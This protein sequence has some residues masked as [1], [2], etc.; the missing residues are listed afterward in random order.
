M[1]HN[2]RIVLNLSAA[3][4]LTAVFLGTFAKP[5][6]S[7][8]TGFLSLINSYR[9]QSGAGALAEDQNL[10]NSACWLAADMGNKGYFDHTDSLGRTMVQRLNAFGV[11][12]SL[13]ENIFYTTA[14]SS[15]NYAFDAWKNS[16]GH[17]ANML[18]SA[19]TRIGIG[20][21]NIHSRWFW[22][23]DFANGSAASL[24][25]QCEAT[26]NSPPPPSV[27]P[28]STPAPPLP[29]QT[30]DVQKPQPTQVATNATVQAQTV[31]NETTKSATLSSK[32]VRFGTASANN[33]GVS[34]LVKNLEIALIGLGN[35]VLF[36]VLFWRFYNK[37]H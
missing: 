34:V 11:S 31:L 27:K 1:Q 16:H 35:L 19:Y 9:Q 32:T 36:G 8:T 14:G 33:F 22:A 29:T 23:T 13:A 20:R 26:T 30:V 12:G 37:F 28:K 18:N 3:C 5:A 2:F 25:N 24:T 15:A 10:T 21:V 7:D 4:L 17:N 6:Y